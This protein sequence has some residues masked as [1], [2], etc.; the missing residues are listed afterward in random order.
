[1]I[2]GPQAKKAKQ[3]RELMSS[4]SKGEEVLTNGGLVGKIQKVS[5]EMVYCN[6]TQ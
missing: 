6:R 4:L 3:H 2:Y 1:M 5:E